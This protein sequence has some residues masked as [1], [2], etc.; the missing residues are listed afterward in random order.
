V[1]KC[2]LVVAI[3]FICANVHAIEAP[4]F[5]KK[6]RASED[7]KAA[8]KA[9]Q[10]KKV[11]PVVPVKP[12]LVQPKAV[13]VPAPSVIPAQPVAPQKK[14]TREETL[15]RIKELLKNRPNIAGAIKGLE[16][17]QVPGGAATYVYN[18]AALESLDDD[19]LFK[20]LSTINQQITIENLQRLDREQRQLKSLQQINQAN[21]TQRMLRDQRALSRPAVPKAYT[22][23]PKP[24]RTRY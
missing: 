14:L 11:V 7:A 16:A 8:A 18:G 10:V 23:P 22:P 6:W 1:K 4:A 2:A 9:A 3:M 12:V 13:P 21:R 5:F 19:T 17:K 24:P 20:I 15:A